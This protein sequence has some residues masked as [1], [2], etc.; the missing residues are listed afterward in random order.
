MDDRPKP[1]RGHSSL[2]TLLRA[3]ESARANRRRLYG[4][5]AI[6]GFGAYVAYAAWDFAAHLAQWRLAP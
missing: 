5:I 4:W 6:W 3:R 2:E 1:R